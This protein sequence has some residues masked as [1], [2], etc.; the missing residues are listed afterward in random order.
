[1][2]YALVHCNTT[3]QGVAAGCIAVF[4]E[5]LEDEEKRTEARIDSVIDPEENDSTSEDSH[6]EE[7]ASSS[8]ENIPISPVV[9]GLM[10]LGERKRLAHGYMANK[11][12]NQSVKF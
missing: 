6:S 9:D 10:D 7:N 12:S 8:K 1:M 4:M 11:A 2:T 3:T 5:K